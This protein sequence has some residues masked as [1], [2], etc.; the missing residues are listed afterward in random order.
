MKV[1]TNSSFKRRIF[2]IALFALLLFGSAKNSNAQGQWRV[3]GE[4]DSHVTGYVTS[5]AKDQSGNIYA[6]LS[7]GV[8]KYDGTKWTELGAYANG[9]KSSSSQ[10]GNGIVIVDHSGNVYATWDS[11]N[12][13][14]FVKKFNGTNWTSLPQ[15]GWYPFKILSLVADVNGNLFESLQDGSV[16]KWNGIAWTMILTGNSTF[17]IH[18]MACDGTG[19]LYTTGNFSSSGNAYVDV[20]DGVSWTELSAGAGAN[21]QYGVVMTDDQDNVYASVLYAGNI[22]AGVA[23]WNGTT[24]TE[25]GAGPATLNPYDRIT[26]LT[27]DGQHNIYAAGDLT[28]SSAKKIVA[29]WNGISWSELGTGV[30]G[31]SSKY[32]VRAVIADYAGNI[33]ATVDNYNYDRDD[34]CYIAKWNGTNWNDELGATNAALHSYNTIKGI[35]TDE[36]NN[37][38]VTACLPFQQPSPDQQ[39]APTQ[40]YLAKW[41]GTVWSAASTPINSNGL[42]KIKRDSNGNIYA[43]GSLFDANNKTYVAKWDGSSWTELG[44]GISALNANAGIFT[45]AIDHQD[46]IYVAGAFTNANSKTYVAKWDGNSWTELGSGATALNGNNYIVDIAVDNAGNVYAGGS[47]TNAAGKQYVAKWNGTGWSDMGTVSTSFNEYSYITKLLTDNGGNI[48]AAWSFA[49]GQGNPYIVK[50]NGTSWVQFGASLNGVNG[51]NNLLIDL[52]GNL[53]AAVRYLNAVPGSALVKWNGISWEESGIPTDAIH[54]NWNSSRPDILDLAMDSSGTLYATGS[55]FD[56]RVFFQVAKLE[57]ASIYTFTGNGSWNDAANW[58]NN[59]KP[60]ANLPAGSK[61]IINPIAGGQ[62]IL[63]TVQTISPNAFFTI[64]AG[65]HFVVTGNLINNQ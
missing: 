24:W 3:L 36:A 51:I 31:I 8:F 43:I 16:Y 28:N 11:V 19:K 15:A 47:F 55:F 6:V 39:S 20:W 57:A 21:N 62:C 64:S 4:V 40:Q 1:F 50:W 58:Q 29:K 32:S 30:N 48:Y 2:P 23:K 34:S 49:N 22:H 44:T 26:T 45:I 52:A 41:N 54:D 35:V 5:L 46:N 7:N 17:P 37:V 56:S 27:I 60:A 13:D 38:Y 10:G 53:Y 25:L 63:S 14:C 33:C 9:L 42:T 65:A 61:I 59:L 18:S 12:G